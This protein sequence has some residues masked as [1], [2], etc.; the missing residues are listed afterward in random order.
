[1]TSNNS[2]SKERMEEHIKKFKTTPD[3]CIHMNIHFGM[4]WDCGQEWD[5]NNNPIIH[6]DKAFGCPVNDCPFESADE[7]VVKQHMQSHRPYRKNIY[8]AETEQDKEQKQ[9]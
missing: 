8:Y 2:V 9:K 6:F 4:C 3:V 5:D 1:M 7:D